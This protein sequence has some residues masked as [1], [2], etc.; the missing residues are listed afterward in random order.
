MPLNDEIIKVIGQEMNKL[1][2]ECIGEKTG[3][4]IISQARHAKQGSTPT[5]QVSK[6]QCQLTNVR[7]KTNLTVSKAQR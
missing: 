7:M 6:A 1:N 2:P 3:N 5:Y 4:F